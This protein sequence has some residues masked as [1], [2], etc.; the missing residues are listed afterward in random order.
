MYL[1]HTKKKQWI[2]REVIINN[3]EDIQAEALLQMPH[4][5][6]TSY[7]KGTDV[8]GDGILLQP[9]GR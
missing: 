9:Y 2:P 6:L 7:T 4:L 8:Y 1:G 5:V 3:R